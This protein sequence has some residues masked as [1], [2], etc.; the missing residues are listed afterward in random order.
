LHTVSMVRRDTAALQRF[1]ATFVS[2][3]L[4]VFLLV[5]SACGGGGSTA[6][7][8]SAISIKVQ[9][10]DQ[11]AVVGEKATFSVVASGDALYQWQ[12]SA[13]GTDWND[14]AG[15][16][17]AS[18]TTA[19]VSMA[20]DG[21]RFRVLVR[22]QSDSTAGLTSSSVTLTVT[23]GIVAAAIVQQP[24]A[25]SLSEGQLAKFAVTATG[26]ALS[27]QWER[28]SDGSTWTAIDG[29]TAAVLDLG[30]ASLETNGSWYRVTVSN[31]AGSLTSRAALLTVAPALAAPVFT[32][33]PLDATVVA[34]SSATFRVEVTGHPEPTVSWQSTTNGTVWVDIPGSED[35]SYTTT[36]TSPADNG[37]QF[38]AVATNSSGSVFSSHVTLTVTSAPIAPSIVSQPA[39]QTVG[40]DANASFS[41]TANG[42]APLTYQWQVSNDGGVKYVNVTS[43]TSASAEI[44]PISLSDDQKRYRVVV[45]NDAGSVTSET[46]LLTVMPAPQ[47]IVHPQAQGWRQGEMAAMF[48]V[49]AI[50]TGLRY[51]WQ[52]TTDYRTYTNIAGATSASY[53]HGV[54]APPSINSVRVVVANQ[55]G[56]TASQDAAIESL[57]WA[58][59]VP[60]PT[61]DDLYATSWLNS[62]VAVAVGYNGTI[63][64][65]TDA[66]LSWR[67]VHERRTGEYWLNDVAFNG[68]TIGVAVGGTSGR[69]KRSVDSGAN[70]VDIRPDVLWAA[71]ATDVAF[72]NANTVVLVTP[73]GEI[74][75]SIDAGLTWA[76]AVR[77]DQPS[78]LHD[79]D[80]AA[81]GVGLA[82]GSGGT[83]LRSINAGANWAPASNSSGVAFASNTVAVA[84]GADGT[85]R[86]STDGG[87]TWAAAISPT[88][89]EITSIEF[90]DAVK[91]VITD[92]NGRVYRTVDGGITWAAVPMAANLSAGHAMGAQPAGI[93]INVGSDGRILRSTDSGAS[94]AEV[95]SVPQAGFDFASIDFSPSA[96]GAAV[97]SNGLIMRSATMGA[98][99]SA[100][101]SGTLENLSEVAFAS[102][103]VAVAVG[104]GGTILRSADAGLSWS[105]TLTGVSGYF[106]SVAFA[107]A[108]V[109]VAS[110][111]SGLFRT[112]DGGLTWSLVAGTEATYVVAVAFG[113][114]TTGVAVESSD[115][116]LR[117]T[118]GGQTWTAINVAANQGMTSVDFASPTAVVAVGPSGRFMRSAD[119]GQT[120]TL[121]TFA[122]HADYWYYGVRFAS[123]TVGLAVGNFGTVQR[124]TDG[125]L[126]WAPIYSQK[127][128]GFEAVAFADAD[129]AV[130]VGQAVIMRNPRYRR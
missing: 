27:Y 5:L 63:V 81:N 12:R 61:G 10:I 71:D 44:G 49:E 117:T 89:N 106:F 98:D 24:S 87:V 46:A 109:G 55:I 79:I 101:A 32:D 4:A 99:W 85:M 43:S 116:V 7:A 36:P 94:W 128:S 39:D 1:G 66:G 102:N 114:S 58:Y 3:F 26:T 105:T 33:S 125:G 130:A 22:S 14:V 76:A 56:S 104:S 17:K 40:V 28:S 123:P 60:K 91:G 120:W 51:Q 82:V 70:W 38:R 69:I 107:S 75:R 18:H 126:T 110:S 37:K 100:V 9:P 23:D 48:R 111:D 113:N 96:I 127:G 19:A 59:A 29:A 52:S 84:A 92:S 50:G 74:F 13:N 34:G 30:W 83:I 118:D 64:R 6:S 103:N 45:S 47:I 129:T 31:A 73:A 54:N 68:S 86:R 93:V 25:V 42:T 121:G 15:A 21:M 65:S 67:I 16:T 88:A 124:T 119:G 41:V 20:E 78:A 8:S 108:D 2:L 80:F 112:T 122:E 77:S 11:S 57:D 97:G 72:A 95:T 115:R 90:I 53:M 62:S 35:R